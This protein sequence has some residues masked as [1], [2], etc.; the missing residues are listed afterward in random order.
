M[1]RTEDDTMHDDGDEDAKADDE[2]M[3]AN[4]ANE[5][6]KNLKRC[7]RR[8]WWLRGRRPV[9]AVHGQGW[10]RGMRGDSI[11]FFRFGSVLHTH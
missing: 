7:S 5:G 8:W 3:A 1:P 2:D 11:E 4:G 9:L 10:Q 6:P